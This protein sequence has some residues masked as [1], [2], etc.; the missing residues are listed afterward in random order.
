MRY[1]R[2]QKTVGGE[3]VDKGVFTQSTARQYLERKLAERIGEQQELRI[4]TST[5]NSHR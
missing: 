4:P 1:T 3:I 2:S 5:I